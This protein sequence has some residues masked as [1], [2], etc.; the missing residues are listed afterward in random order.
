MMIKRTMLKTSLKQKN[1]ALE[2]LSYLV[3]DVYLF[4]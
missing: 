1:Y 4:F 3:V 2:Y